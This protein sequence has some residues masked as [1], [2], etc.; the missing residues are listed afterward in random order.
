MAS[1]ATE[2]EITKKDS[3]SDFEATYVEPV[4]LQ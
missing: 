1:E 2:V 4:E 3:F